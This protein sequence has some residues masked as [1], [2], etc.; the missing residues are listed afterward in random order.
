VAALGADSVAV[1]AHKL[2]GPKGA[3]AL[4]LRRG[5]RLTPLWSGG[6]QQGGLRSGTLAVPMICALAEA[7]RLAVAALAAEAR[8]L[9]ALRARLEGEVLAA[10][11]AAR[12]NGAGAPRVPH[13]ASLALPGVPAE[14]LLHALEGRGVYVSAGSACASQHKGPSHVLEAIGLAEDVGTLR[15]SFSRETTEEEVALAARAIVEEARGLA[16]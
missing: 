1:S 14:P 9:E 12:V 6:G 5:A 4:W 15:V 10:G 13:I 3:G 2:H 8:R 16:R 11:L 7:A